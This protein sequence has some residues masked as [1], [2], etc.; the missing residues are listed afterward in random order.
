MTDQHSPIAI[1]CLNSAVMLELSDA[2][3]AKCNA[4]NRKQAELLRQAAQMADVWYSALRQAE[5]YLDSRADVV[6]GSYG[7]PEPNAEMS[8]LSEIRMAMGNVP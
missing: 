2:G 6:D 5:D 1:C 4:L 8:L 3:N 7:V